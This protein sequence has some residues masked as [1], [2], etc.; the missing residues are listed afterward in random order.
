[1]SKNRK[2]MNGYYSKNE[3]EVTADIEEANKDEI[4][5]VL[6]EVEERPIEIRHTITK[7]NVRS[8]TT[9][10]SDILKV[11]EKGEKVKGRDLGN[12]WFEHTDG[13]YTM[14]EYIK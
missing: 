5:D 2:Y 3:I 4:E 1:M 11:L 9:K 10:N 13:G 7:V 6:K 12:G 14:I 8:R